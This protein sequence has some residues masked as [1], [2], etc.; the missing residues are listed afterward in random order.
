MQAYLP[1]PVVG[2][3]INANLRLKI[4][5]GFH[6]S[7]LKP[8]FGLVTLRAPSP[9]RRLER[10]LRLSSRSLKMFFKATIMVRIK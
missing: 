8:S 7:P 9:K 10:R 1:G 4:N 3:P 6:S 5:R 2:K